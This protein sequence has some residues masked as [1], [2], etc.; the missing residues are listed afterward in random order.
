MCA[1]SDLGLTKTRIRLRGFFNFFKNKNEK[2]SVT[3]V[4]FNLLEQKVLAVFYAH[5]KRFKKRRNSD[6]WSAGSFGQEPAITL[7]SFFLGLKYLHKDFLKKLYILL[8]FFEKIL[9]IAP[10][11]LLRVL[12]SLRIIFYF[13][14][15]LKLLNVYYN[16]IIYSFFVKQIFIS[17][18]LNTGTN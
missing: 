11:V 1:I 15:I 8:L 6:K 4:I 10:F 3:L 17:F 16:Y 5:L 14:N 18:L 12:S 9:K 13:L 2:W 7:I